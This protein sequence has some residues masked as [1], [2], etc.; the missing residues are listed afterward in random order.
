M[1]LPRKTC[2]RRLAIRVDVEDSASRLPPIDSDNFSIE[3]SDVRDEV[4]LIV[5][6]EHI[7]DGCLIGGVRVRRRS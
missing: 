3:K 4:L 2:S 7:R 6:C 5:R 1:A